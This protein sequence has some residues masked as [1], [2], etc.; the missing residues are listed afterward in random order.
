MWL[1]PAHAGSTALRPPRGGPSG[2]HPRSRGEHFGIALQ[3]LSI[4]GSSP[5][6]RGARERNVLVVLPFGLIPAHAGSTLV[7]PC[8]S[9]P[10]WAHPRSR[11]E[12]QKEEGDMLTTKGS[13]PLTR[14]A[15]SSLVSFFAGAGLIPA[16]AGS[17]PSRTNSSALFRAHPR[18]RG[19]HPRWGD[20]HWGTDGSSPLTRGARAAVRLDRQ[21]RGLIPAHAGSTRCLS[22]GL[23]LER[24]HPRS[25]GEHAEGADVL[26]V[27]DGLIPAHAGSTPPGTPAQ[28]YRGAHPR[29]RG[30]HLMDVGLDL[31]DWGSSPLTRGARQPLRVHRRDDGLI[32]A[33]AGSTADTSRWRPAGRAHPRSR[34]EHSMFFNPRF[35][36]GGSSPLTRGALAQEHHVFGD[37]GLIPAHAGSTLWGEVL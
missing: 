7:S 21:G 6:T 1:I 36:R 37:L 8:S 31:K 29:S 30:E 16:H 17:T 4:V 5:L 34:G 11:G 15:R 13:S 26:A 33:H 19:E 24:A 35:W 10:S 12:H 2:A 32:P 18:S 23:S 28:A 27:L 20:I 14:G 25:R 9:C 22:P 3:F